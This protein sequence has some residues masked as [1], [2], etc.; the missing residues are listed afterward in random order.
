MTRSIKRAA[1]GLTICFSIL[2]L[3]LVYWQFINS[4]ELLTK[5]GNL[6]AI[7]MEQE[8][9]RGGI[10]D[11]NGEIL[12]KSYTPDE[13]LK[14]VGKKVMPA[15]R[16]P[17]S[18]YPLQVRYF[19]QGDLFAHVVGEYSFIYGK[20]G[21][22]SSL[23]KTL[24]G[25]GPNESIESAADQL[26]NEPRRGNDVVLTLD[27]KIQAAAVEGLAGKSGAAVAINPKTGEILAMA[28][29]PTFDPNQLDTNYQAINAIGQQVFVNKAINA[30]F[31]PGST[32]KLVTAGALLRSGIDVNQVYN[33]TGHDRVK[34]NGESRDVVDELQGGY[35]NVDFYKALAYSSNTY[36][37]TRA[38]MAGSSQFLAAT[39]RFGFGQQ[40]PLWELENQNNPIRAGL[41]NSTGVPSQLNLGALMDSAYGQAQVQ[42]TP[43]HMAMIGAA[44]A[45]NG[46]M[47]RPA[48]VEK[49]IGPNQQTVY[50]FQPEVWLNPLNPGEA[51]EI[52]QGMLD[53][54]Q[55]GT[56]SNLA[57][58][59]ISMAA[60]T[61][62]A[63]TGD[64]NKPANGWFVAFAPAD[65]PVIAVAVLVEGGGT[66]AGS[67]GPIARNMILAA[68]RESR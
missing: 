54:V 51:Q 68:V 34:A 29:A 15:I 24:L 3:G 5:P 22:E 33:D 8:I 7:Y 1:L 10:F 46:Q 42:V 11:R 36:F 39:R 59:G 41:V 25:L 67:A 37:A 6:R 55:Y 58:P 61:G 50:R 14:L 40:I 26:I 35:G 47:M 66:G 57:I 12:A 17:G 4:D 60:K 23:N 52:K 28:S 27:S 19:P 62:S 65:N 16:P 45:N 63:E 20:T 48:L 31:A 49:V 38:A 32:M 18:N 64:R 53:A 13:M 43:L 21:L 44:I 9:W 56:A 30:T 2:S